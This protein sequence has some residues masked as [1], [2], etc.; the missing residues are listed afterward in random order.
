MSDL[1]VPILD[2]VKRF[3]SPSNKANVLE[4]YNRKL[5][6]TN[7]ELS[8]QVV[9]LNVRLAEKL[10]QYKTGSATLTHN[11]NISLKKLKDE[12][13]IKDTQVTELTESNTLLK[14]QHAN[15]ITKLAT[16]LKN[17][18][19][20]GEKLKKDLL[21]A[22]TTIKKLNEEIVVLKGNTRTK[23][24]SCATIVKIKQAHDNGSSYEELAKKYKRSITTIGNIV[25]GDTYK[26]C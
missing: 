8:N 17:L 4:E 21:L 12:F 26:H 19:E 15:E 6:F 13:A 23:H 14:Q 20:Y 1:N 11:F 25:R 9:T 5:E 24:L 3:L 22:N 7:R 2:R 18:K 10:K 16:E